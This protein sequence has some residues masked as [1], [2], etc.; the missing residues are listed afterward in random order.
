MPELPEVETVRIGLSKLIIG[1]KISAVD[2]D[3][4][5]AF[6][7]SRS[8]LNDRIIGSTITTVSRRG[9]LLIIALDN[10]YSMLVHLRMTGQLVYRSKKASFGA[11]HPSDSLVGKLPDKS[12]R[13]IISFSDNSNLF[14]NDQRKFG[15]V[16]LIPDKDVFEI[17]FLKK[18]GPEPLS[19][20][21]D[22]KR[23]KNALSSRLNSQIKAVLLDQNVIAGIGNIYAD[24][25]LWLAK[26]HPMNKVNKISEKK[27]KLLHSSIIDVLKLSIE[28]GGSTDRNY[29]NAEGK[30]GSYI[31]FANVFRKENRPCPRC[32]IIV[33]KIRV[34][35]R[36]THI[37]TNCQRRI[38]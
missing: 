34:A 16:D 1:K 8:D 9:K 37:C 27:L 36:G 14:F 35:G 29:V 13:V 2:F 6:K 3:W 33:K 26:I 24:E 15:W 21:F 20:N 23:F 38:M 5:K 7:A 12:T 32:G 22:Y 30:K 28:K 31:E 17:P 10:N 11:G 25:S 4:K 19:P 18:M